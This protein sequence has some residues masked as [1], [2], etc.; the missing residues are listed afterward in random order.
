MFDKFFLFSSISSPILLYQ[1]IYDK[2]SINNKKDRESLDRMLGKNRKK[3]NHNKNDA[4]KNENDNNNTTTNNRQHEQKSSKRGNFLP[5]EV[6]YVI[7]GVAAVATFWFGLTIV[8]QVNNPFYVVSSESMVPTLMV[9]DLVVLRNGA[10]GGGFSFS[11]LQVG[12]IIVFHTEDGGGRTIVHRI[13]EIYQAENNNNVDSDRGTKE[14]DRLVKT[15]GDNNP[16]SYEV[17][18]YPISEADYYGKVISIIPKVGLVTIPPYNYVIAGVAAG[19]LSVTGILGY[20]VYQK[21]SKKD[22]K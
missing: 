21:N 19:L 20:V 15:K 18:D 17:L 4:D 16:V 3:N 10:D 5:N 11:D 14:G 12:D 1:S 13:V 2:Q 9:G 22:K 8:L 6:K 7:I